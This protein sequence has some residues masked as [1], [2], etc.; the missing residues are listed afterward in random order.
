MRK[1][2]TAAAVAAL[3]PLAAARADTAIISGA[4]AG[5]GCFIV[6]T[7]QGGGIYS[8]ALEGYGE[9]ASLPQVLRVANQASLISA[10]IGKTMA[11]N[12]NGTVTCLDPDHGNKPTQFTVIN[13]LRVPDDGNHD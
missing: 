2:L 6:L 1:L 3:L 7:V 5:G 8:L 4:K 11:Y 10:N 13:N 12:T 9:V